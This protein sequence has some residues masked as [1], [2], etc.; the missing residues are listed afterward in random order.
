MIARAGLL[1]LAFGL[2][3]CGNHPTRAACEEL[4]DHFIELAV[5][6]YEVEEYVTMARE[7]AEDGRGRMIARCEEAGSNKAIECGMRAETIADFREC[8]LQF[9]AERAKEKGATGEPDDAKKSDAKAVTA[10]PAS[11]TRTPP[12]AKAQATPAEKAPAAPEAEAPAPP[13]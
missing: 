5:G 4:A 13:E 1:I 3:G 6:E 10:K 11:E 8:R 7:I 9:A 12:E 2:A